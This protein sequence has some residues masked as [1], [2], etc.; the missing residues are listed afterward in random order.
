MEYRLLLRPNCIST[1]FCEVE[2]GMS[3][4]VESA[5]TNVSRD[6]IRVRGPAPLSEKGQGWIAR[7]ANGPRFL[8]GLAGNGAI[9]RIQHGMSEH[10]QSQ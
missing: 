9:V 2:T 1:C 3:G 7:C 8:R 4:T 6:Y 10:W 5:W